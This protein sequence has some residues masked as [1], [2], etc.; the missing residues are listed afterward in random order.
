VAAQ[1]IADVGNGCLEEDT[2]I[3][4]ENVKLCVPHAF[5][6]HIS[7]CFVFQ[8]G[9][10][11]MDVKHE[12]IY[13][14]G[15]GGDGGD[16]GI[17]NSIMKAGLGGLGASASS[18]CLSD[19]LLLSSV[20]TEPRV[21]SPCDPSAGT[22][23]SGIELGHHLASSATATSGV[24]PSSSGGAVTPNGGLFSGISASNKR[25]RVDDWLPSP[26]SGS[27][28]HLPPLTPSPGPPG[29]PYTVISN[30]YSSP[31]SSGS[32]EPYSPNGKIGKYKVIS[33]NFIPQRDRRY[34]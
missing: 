30:G 28:G 14:V 25:P 24:A 19:E 27:A 1:C 11:V 21:H 15:G 12:L 23:A 17:I 5:L 4:N 13:R 34:N 18:S 22:T 20:K 9:K 31:L 26:S 16:G 8:G 6:D 32:Y 7:N 10:G 29:H 33:L 3:N 2:G